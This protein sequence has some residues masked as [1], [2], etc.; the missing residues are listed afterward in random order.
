M[1]EQ[2]TSPGELIYLP[3]S[4][5]GYRLPAEWE[6]HE[7]TWLVW[8][9]D[10]SL[11]KDLNSFNQIKE[12]LSL[13]AKLSYGQENINILVQTKQTELELTKYLNNKKVPID[14]DFIQ[15]VEIPTNDVWIRDYGPLW[16]IRDRDNKKCIVDFHSVIKEEQEKNGLNEQVSLQI[17]SD[18]GDGY[19][20]GDSIIPGHVFDHNGKGTFLL[21]E[22]D[23]TDSDIEKV[24]KVFHNWL[25]AKKIIWIANPEENKSDNS[26]V[27]DLGRFIAPNVIIMQLPDSKSDPTWINREAIIHQVIEE[28]EGDIVVYPIP[29]VPGALRT[30]NYLNFYMAN[31]TI[32]VPV[33]NKPTDE[34]ALNIISS[35]LPEKVVQP[36]DCSYIGM[37]HCLTLQE[38]WVMK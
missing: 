12:I 8:P 1:M 25:G 38:P 9:Y 32:F 5:L 34:E 37:L 4:K 11:W 17:A 24:E 29:T 10:E 2:S 22:E 30:V 35:I 15:F 20:G 7:A 26:T 33:F 21:R 16:M 36:V 23:W 3:P 31:N 14:P 13:I 27:Q 18:F 19:F 28:G 6:R